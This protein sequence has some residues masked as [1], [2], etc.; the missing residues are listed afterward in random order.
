MIPYTLYIL[1][2]A[3]FSP[4]Q[5]FAKVDFLDWL[6][7]FSIITLI[8]IAILIS[9]YFR[10]GREDYRFWVTIHFIVNIHV[11]ASTAVAVAIM[12]QQ[13]FET[14]L[15][16]LL[17]IMIAVFIAIA[18]VYSVFG[19][20]EKYLPEFN[21]MKS[22]IEDNDFN[23]R[24][25]EPALLKDSVFGPIAELINLT[26]DHLTRII[27]NVQDSISQ[28]V[29]SSE[30]LATTSDEMNLLS[31]E[32]ASTIQ[33]ISRGSSVQSDLALQSFQF[34]NEMS[35]AVD[36]S[37]ARIEASIGIIQNIAEQTNILALNAAIEAARAGEYGRGFAVVADNVR[38]LSEETKTNSSEIT[39]LMNEVT[40]GIKGNV[41][42]LQD[43]LQ[44][45][46]T[47]SEEYAA[48]AEEVVAATEEKSASMNQ[49]NDAAQRLKSL[50]ERL[51]EVIVIQ[52]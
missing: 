12:S 21:E 11:I 46:T 33:Q 6:A 20:S 36:D 47:Q 8:A 18:S 48:S 28:V 5:Q 27:V 29:N 2:A 26:L 30:E 51:S 24:L 31:E 25:D 9:A 50:G 44:G 43:S 13:G 40:S 37:L 49:L 15:E 38:R 45:F 22:Q 42:Q 17:P 32:I 10:I 23:A 35:K 39:V 3:Y 4:D 41:D 16:T 14:T 52:E 34:T 7:Y 19:I 1:L